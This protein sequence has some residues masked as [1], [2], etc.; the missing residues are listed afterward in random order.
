[1]KFEPGTYVI[2]DPCYAFNSDEWEK[3]CEQMFKD[4]ENAEVKMPTGS[5]WQHHTAY[6]AGLFKDD[7]GCEYGVDSGT[8][9]VVPLAMANKEKMKDV[10]HL[11]RVMNFAEAFEPS[12][13]D[14]TFTFGKI[15]ISTG[16]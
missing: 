6:G 15:T 4:P 5:F 12:Y 2:C 16:G 3:V 1:M 13:K 7:S 10:M 11:I 14:G 8:L 9:G